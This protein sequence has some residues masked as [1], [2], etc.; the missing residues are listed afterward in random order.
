MAISASGSRPSKLRDFASSIRRSVTCGGGDMPVAALKARAKWNG[1]R[2]PQ[3]ANT[4]WSGLRRGGLDEIPPPKTARVERHRR[5]PAAIEMRIQVG[6][7]A[8]QVNAERQRPIASAA[9]FPRRGIGHPAR[10]PR[11]IFD[12]GIAKPP[13]ISVGPFG[14]DV[15]FLTPFPRAAEREGRVYVSRTS[16]VKSESCLR[17]HLG[18]I[19]NRA[20]D[21]VAILNL[22]SRGA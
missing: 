1:L 3:F 14:I 15:D 6:M 18:D 11:A 17:E 20:G 22:P 4:R 12:Q 8:V 7:K 10:I 9:S 16:P 21:C 5:Q 13:G 2:Q 19:A